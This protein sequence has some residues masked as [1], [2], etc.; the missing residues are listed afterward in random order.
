VR[1][2]LNGDRFEVVGFVRG[3]VGAGLPDDDAELALIGGLAVMGDG[4]FDHGAQGGDAGSGFE[5]I[6]RLGRLR[7]PL[8]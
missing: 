3:N 2:E 7:I 1:R 4:A 8:I 6:E 5:E